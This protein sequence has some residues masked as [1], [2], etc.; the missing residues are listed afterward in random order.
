MRM[1]NIRTRKPR[2]DE[3]QRIPLTYELYAKNI[4]E[5]NLKNDLTLPIPNTPGSQT[6]KREIEQMRKKKHGET[7]YLAVVPREE[8]GTSNNKPF[9]SFI[10]LTFAQVSF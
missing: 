5:L 9:T 3:S 10:K 4:E 2:P 8:M 7:I 6:V 1:S